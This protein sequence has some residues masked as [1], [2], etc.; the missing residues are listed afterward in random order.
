[1]KKLY[2]IITLMLAIVL[3]S[4]VVGC[5]KAPDVDEGGGKEIEIDGGGLNEKKLTG[6][7]ELQVFSNGS[8]DS[9]GFEEVLARFEEANPDLEV[10]LR[11]GVNV[12]TQ[13]LTRWMNDTPPDLVI[14]SGAGFPEDTIEAAGKFYDMSTW[15]KTAKVWGT[16]TLITDALQDG[17]L[18]YNGEKLNKM[19]MNWG[20]YGLWYDQAYFAE[21]NLTM[22]NSYEELTA[23]VEKADALGKSAICYPGV[24]SGYLV[25]GLVMPAIAAYGD[26]AFFEKIS[27]ATD[28]SAFTDARMQEVLQRLYDLAGKGAFMQGTVQ[29]N[30]I[31]SQME[32]L[33]HKSLIIPNGLWLESEMADDTPAKFA[34]KFSPTSLA[35]ADQGNYVIPYISKLAVAKHGQNVENALAFVRFL[36]R[37]ENLKSMCEVSGNMPVT[38]VD[39]SAWN[40]TAS[41]KESIGAIT[42]ENVKRTFLRASWGTVDSEFNN[43]VNSLVLHE[44]TPDEACQRL[45]TACETKIAEAN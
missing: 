7:L 34:M 18:I 33:N 24:Y 20:A 3:L 40:Y 8:E 16:D 28:P 36:Y 25:W 41:A 27:G 17:M 10:T 29:L 12:H 45:K 15:I 19:P 26:E 1:M 37:E 22:P 11:I 6:K 14:L 9:K 13:M 5:Q 31:E 35:T 32:W 21:N 30:H 44:I 39:Y 2:R 43:V 38:D 23:F 42:G 4:T